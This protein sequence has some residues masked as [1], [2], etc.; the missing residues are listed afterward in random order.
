MYKQRAMGVFSKHRQPH[1]VVGVGTQN[2][3]EPCQLTVASRNTLR[4]GV[5]VV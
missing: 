3:Q 2:P 4:L 1:V 5:C